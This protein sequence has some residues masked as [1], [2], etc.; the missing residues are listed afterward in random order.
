MLYSKI[1]L[2]LGIIV[3]LMPFSGFPG[4]WKFTGYVTIGVILI[5]LSVLVEIQ[6][7]PRSEP[8]VSEEQPQPESPDETQ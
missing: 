5:L 8:E 3:S 1:V 2:L 7:A 4:S 6:N